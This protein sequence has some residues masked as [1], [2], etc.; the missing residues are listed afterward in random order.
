MQYNA[1]EFGKYLHRRLSSSE[2]TTPERVFFFQWSIHDYNLISF[3]IEIPNELT[4][5]SADISAVLYT[6]ICKT[7]MKY[8]ACEFQHVYD[9]GHNLKNDDCTLDS[10][11]P[12]LLDILVSF[13]NSFVLSEYHR[14]E[15]R[16]TLE[17]YPS[18]YIGLIIRWLT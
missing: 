4:E 18:A 9:S 12:S 5:K 2:T 3:I 17:K 16:Y 8:C 7:R 10:K 14:L 1:F 11:S 15:L 13:R 6:S